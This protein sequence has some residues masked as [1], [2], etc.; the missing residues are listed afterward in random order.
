[1]LIERWG[2]LWRRMGFR[3]H[4]AV[5]N[6]FRNR[7]RTI[8]GMVASALGT[9]I[10]LSTLVLYD[11]VR[12]M[13]D[14]QFDRVLHSD[15]DIGMRDEAS[16]ASLWEARDLPGVDGAEPVLAVACTLRNGAA[17]RRVSVTGLS[18]DH[19][20]TTPLRADGRPIELPPAGLVMSGKLA[21]VLGVGVGGSV[22]LTPIRGERVT[23]HVPVA[24]I[25]EGYFGL[26]C[27]AEISYLSSLVGESAAVNSVQLAV[28]PAGTGA[29]YR[30]I[31]QLPNAQ[32]L[33]V[34]SQAKAN[35]EATFVASMAATLGLTVLFAGVIAFGTTLNASL[36]ELSDRRRE[37]ATLH[38]MGYRPRQIAGIFFRES[39]LVFA[40][41]ML[42]AIPLSWA[43]VQA[44]AAAY[45][46]ELYRMP[47]VFRPVTTALAL[48]VTALFL[49]IAQLV[50]L[51]Q[52]RRTN[53]L[54]AIKIQ[55]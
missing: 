6:L 22:A 49:L 11:S 42:L 40:C 3:T 46:T 35:I 25:V 17:R 4:M 39:G 54:E 27:Y 52:I 5:R 21:E 14:F 51:R 41:G 43:L 44:M 34:R 24:S 33:S 47:V 20:L 18:G 23:R 45:D 37:I 32:G 9:A 15:A 29:L 30:R 50:V 28:N 1:V 12:H 2:W 26:A 48:G 16:I 13:V 10:V 7:T 36:M 53:W 55:E 8:T 38:A 31:K 19:R